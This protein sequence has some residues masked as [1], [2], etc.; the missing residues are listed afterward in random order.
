MMD[1]IA[2]GLTLSDSELWEKMGYSDAKTTYVL[3]NKDDLSREF[4]DL[5]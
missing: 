5:Y 1:L 4:G 2:G 3:G